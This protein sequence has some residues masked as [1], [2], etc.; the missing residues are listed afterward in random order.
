M[1]IKEPLRMGVDFRSCGSREL[2]LRALLS[3]SQ[4]QR[5]FEFIALSSLPLTYT[6]SVN[7]TDIEVEPVGALIGRCVLQRQSPVR[8]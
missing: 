6:G 1:P 3:G 7:L 5:K 4:W 8:S 2:I